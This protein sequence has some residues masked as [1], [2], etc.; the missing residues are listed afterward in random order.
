MR[1]KKSD[2]GFYVGGFKY[3]WLSCNVPGKDIVRVFGGMK[4]VL[5][6]FELLQHDGVLFAF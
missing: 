5:V 2:M 6:V 4:D 1:R 3:L